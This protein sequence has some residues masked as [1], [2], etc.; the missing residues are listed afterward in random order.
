MVIQYAS[1][2]HLELERNRDIMSRRPLEV[3]GDVLLLAGDIMAVNDPCE[4]FVDWCAAHYR[5]TFIVPG[6]HDCF[7]GPDLAATLHDWC[8]PLRRNVAYVNNRSVTLDGTRLLL[9]TLWTPIHEA[10]L[11]VAQR[12]RPDFQGVMTLDGAPF[13]A[14]HYGVLH[15]HCRQWL[16][17]QLSLPH[18]GPTVVVTHHCPIVSEDP[19]YGDN[20][21]GSAFCVPL[22]GMIERCGASHW[23]FG[24]THYN[25]ARGTRLG[26]TTLHTNQLGSSSHG[27]RP[28]FVVNAH[29]EV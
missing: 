17:T 16:A 12:D 9:T 5:H 2:L 25:A 14:A 3:A 13:A 1:D 24:H 21:L 29:F 8:L 19:A 20:G 6:N 15:R 10:Q 23:I 18:D 27:P 4:W 7:G 22:D 26:D 28:G 11:V